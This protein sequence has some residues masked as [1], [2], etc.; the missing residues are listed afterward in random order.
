MWCASFESAMPRLH[1]T[2]NYHRNEELLKIT[3]KVKAAVEYIAKE[4]CIGLLALSQNALDIHTEMIKAIGIDVDTILDKTTVIHPP[5]DVFIS[6]EDIEIKYQNLQ[7]IRIVFV[8]NA[9]S[10]K[11]GIELIKVLR[12]IAEKRATRIKLIIISNFTLKSDDVSGV[13]SMELEEILNVIHNSDWIEVYSNLPNSR[14]LELCKGC[15]LGVLPS[16]ADSYGYS[17]LEMQACGMPVITTDIRAFPEINESGWCC[18]IPQNRFKEATGISPGI[19]RDA[20]SNE[21]EKTIDAIFSNPEILLEQAKKA[22]EE[23]ITKHNP[24]DYAM[25]LNDLYSHGINR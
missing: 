9:F 14:V 21:L 7:E 8:G 15:H 6:E 18:H 12:K 19:L 16:Y 20:L 24:K 5:Q 25:K 10:R 3:S 17:V 4:N 22:R 11:G 1:D 2:M 13:T 23:I